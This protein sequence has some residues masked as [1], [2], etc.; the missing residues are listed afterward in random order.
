MDFRPGLVYTREPF[1]DDGELVWREGP[2]ESLDKSV[3]VRCLISFAPDGGLRVL[4][5]NLGRAVEDLRRRAGPPLR[6]G[7]RRRRRGPGRPDGRLLPGRRAGRRDF[8]AVVRNQGPRA[9]G[10]PELQQAHSWSQPGDRG[11][12]VAVVTD[13]RM[14][15][16]SGKVP[17]ALHVTPEAARG[18]PLGKQA[19]RR[20]DP[21]RHPHGHTVGAADADEPTPAKPAVLDT[22]SGPTF[23]TG[24]TVHG[25]RR[26]SAWP[27][28]RH[29][30]RRRETHEHE[31]C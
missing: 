9:N 2:A 24:R 30:R 20:P 7:T 26:R 16:A 23:G 29:R 27:T 18:G 17:A 5:G 31:L 19:R 12:Q 3:L 1:L 13:G 15:G 14:S 11:H 8:V 4:H 10:M 21:A 6:R 25:S 22:P 28:G